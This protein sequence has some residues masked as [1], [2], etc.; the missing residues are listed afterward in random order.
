[1]GLI[2]LALAVTGLYGLIAY[3]V[4]PRIKEFGI[5]VALGATRRDVVWLVERRGL[6]LTAIGIAQARS[7]RR[8]SPMLAAGFPGIGRL[9]PAVCVSV[10]VALLIVSVAAA[11]LPARRAAGYRC[12][13]RDVGPRAISRRAAI[14]YF[15][16]RFGA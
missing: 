12:R 1:M 4:R 16:A 9:S 11:L 13:L 10:A 2:G 8:P 6:I 3:T 5:R 7:S 14:P 15:P